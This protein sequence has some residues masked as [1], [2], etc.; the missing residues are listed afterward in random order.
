MFNFYRP[1]TYY[2]Q[3]GQVMVSIE[4]IVELTNLLSKDIWL[5]I[6]TS[7]NDDYML[8]MAM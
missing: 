7:A 3:A 4:Y 2:T 8:K 1:A 5:S 6:P